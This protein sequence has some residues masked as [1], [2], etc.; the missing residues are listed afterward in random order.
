MNCLI[1]SFAALAASEA[2]CGTVRALLGRFLPDLAGASAPV[3]FGV[4]M[5]G[6]LLFRSLNFSVAQV[7]FA[8]GELSTGEIRDVGF[9]I[10]GGRREYSR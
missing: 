3:F 7:R 1:P 5:V 6:L 2:R 10:Q 4:G 8:D 9:S